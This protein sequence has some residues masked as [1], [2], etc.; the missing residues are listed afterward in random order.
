M[1]VYL[2]VAHVFNT[3]VL[4]LEILQAIRMRTASCTTNTR[5]RDGRIVESGNL[6]LGACAVQ[7]GGAI[8]IQTTPQESVVGM[9][10]I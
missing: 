1:C 3:N 5:W 4:D 6:M 10:L 8:Y 7:C 2:D 9:C